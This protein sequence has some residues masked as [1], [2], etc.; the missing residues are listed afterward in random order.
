MSCVGQGGVDS[1][2]IHGDEYGE[3]ISEDAMRFR[4][5]FSGE[6]KAHKELD[7]KPPHKHAIRTYDGRQL[8]VPTNDK[9]NS[10]FND[11]RPSVFRFI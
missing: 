2:V 4:L 9:Q 3:P 5:L 8:K 7:I 11:N 1:F 6:I 10:R